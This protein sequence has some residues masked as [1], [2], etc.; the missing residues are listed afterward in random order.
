MEFL[1]YQQLQQKPPFRNI[2]HETRNPEQAPSRSGYMW[3]VKK[4]STGQKMPGINSGWVKVSV[5]GMNRSGPFAPNLSSPEQGTATLWCASVA[6]A[7]AQQKPQFLNTL[8]G[9]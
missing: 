9:L 3:D 7:P 4:L 6:L 1:T 2:F 8:P 5:V